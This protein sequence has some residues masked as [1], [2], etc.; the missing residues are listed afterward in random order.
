MNTT[1]ATI[2]KN[3]VFQSLYVGRI[4]QKERRSVGKKLV[5]FLGNALYLPAMV[6]VVWIFL[7]SLTR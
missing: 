4:L 1:D 2:R 5:I 3:S 7:E 6:V